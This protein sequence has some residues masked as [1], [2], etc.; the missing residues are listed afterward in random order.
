VTLPE[1]VTAVVRVR[2]IVLSRHASQA[3]RDVHW[4]ICPVSGINLQ[5]FFFD[6]Y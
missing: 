4:D 2:A 1:G 3:E 6:I 5:R